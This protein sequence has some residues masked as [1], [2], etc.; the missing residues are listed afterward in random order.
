ME[1]SWFE[2]VTHF[3]CGF[4][5]TLDRDAI[6]DGLLAFVFF[7]PIFLGSTPCLQTADDDRNKSPFCEP[8]IHESTRPRAT[9]LAAV[10]DQRVVERSALLEGFNQRGDR[11][12]ASRHSMTAEGMRGR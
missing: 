2:R 12:S 3:A 7:R 1:N 11:L 9:E 10:D 5:K 6:H 4:V 8:S